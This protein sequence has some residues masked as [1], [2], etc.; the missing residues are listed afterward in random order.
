MVFSGRRRHESPTQPSQTPSA[1]LSGSPFVYEGDRA[2][3]RFGRSEAGYK[4]QHGHDRPQVTIFLRGAA[5]VASWF[6][7]SG[8]RVDKPFQDE[9]VWI[10]PAGARHAVRHDKATEFIAVYPSLKFFKEI[11]DGSQISEASCKPLRQYLEE[12]PL[13]GE[14]I[15][16]FLGFRAAKKRPGPIYV[17]MLAGVLAHHILRVFLAPGHRERDAPAGLAPAVLNCVLAHIRSHY[18]DNLSRADLARVAKQS[19]WHFARLFNLSTGMPPMRYLREWRLQ[20]GRELLLAGGKTI[21]EIAQ[22]VGFGDHSQFTNQFRNKYGVSSER[23]RPSAEVSFGIQGRVGRHNGPSRPGA[24]TSALSRR[25][26][27]AFT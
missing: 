4:E 24:D 26:A 11:G 5:G 2:R 20:K 8:R 14:L 23:L 16:K 10:V 9:Q 7:V 12:D 19:K 17:E 6:A 1:A 21:A 3:V 25:K 13:I 18:S 15:E 22:A 27:P